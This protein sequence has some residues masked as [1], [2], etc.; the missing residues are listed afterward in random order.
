MSEYFCFKQVSI[1]GGFNKK[2]HYSS[3]YTLINFGIVYNDITEVKREE[4]GRR[5]N[6]LVVMSVVEQEVLEKW[7]KGKTKLNST[8]PLPC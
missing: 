8:P 4:E 7:Q 1:D 3:T 6:I 2:L 5:K